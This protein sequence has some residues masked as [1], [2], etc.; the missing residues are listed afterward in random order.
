VT[1][2]AT[3]PA[4]TS[5]PVTVPFIVNSLDSGMIGTFTGLVDRNAGVNSG[6]GSQ[7]TLTTSGT[8]Y[9]T[10]KIITGVTVKSVVGYLLATAQVSIPIGG[11][12]LSLTLDGGMNALSHLWRCFR[13]SL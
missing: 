5:T 1:I 6:L 12:A 11:S 13:N 7:F 9:Y 4:G 8:G 2:K 3:N 10:A